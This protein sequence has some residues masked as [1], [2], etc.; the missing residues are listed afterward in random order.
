M[1]QI[2][3][4]MRLRR[5]RLACGLGHFVHTTMGRWDEAKTLIEIAVAEA[6]AGASE[7]EAG[8]TAR[9]LSRRQMQDKENVWGPSYDMEEDF[10][11]C[12]VGWASKAVHATSTLGNVLVSGG[13]YVQALEMYHK[14]PIDTS[15]TA[16]GRGGVPSVVRCDVWS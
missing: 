8:G 4:A 5:F 6:K 7:E 1:W 11:K 3:P 16:G 14:C 12:V 9:E 10:E 15:S 2:G 13:E